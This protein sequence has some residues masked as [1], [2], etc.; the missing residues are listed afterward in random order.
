MVD[1]LEGGSG[2]DEGVVVVL[3]LDDQAPEHHGQEGNF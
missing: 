2:D 3:V 1:N